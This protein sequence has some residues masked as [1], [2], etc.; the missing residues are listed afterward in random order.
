MPRHPRNT[1]IAQPA[2]G[3]QRVYFVLAII[4]YWLNIID[5]QNT[6]TQDLKQ[7]FSGF[8][9]V[10]AGALG[11]PKDWEQEPLWQ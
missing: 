2:T 7:L 8:P 10:H 5:P 6:L 11:F 4:R 3:T 1:F 9:G